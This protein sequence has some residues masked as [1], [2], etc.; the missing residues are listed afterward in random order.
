MKYEILINSVYRL[1]LKKA[2]KVLNYYQSKI[3]FNNSEEQQSILDMITQKRNID[4]NIKNGLFNTLIKR[5]NE[6]DVDVLLDYEKYPNI[7]WT[8]IIE[9]VDK[10]ILKELFEENIDKLSSFLIETYILNLPKKDQAKITDQYLDKLDQTSES[11]YSFYYSLK[12]KTRNKIK[13]KISNK[14]TD[15]LLLKIKDLDESQLVEI[16]KNN[17]KKI[18]KQDSNALVELILKKGT[19]IETYNLF[20]ELYRSK[21]IKCSNSNFKLLFKKY[22][23]LVNDYI[24]TNNQSKIEY[25]KNEKIIEDTILFDLF[26][27]KFYKIGV[28][29]T[30]KLF[31]KVI[32]YGCDDFTVHVVLELISIAFLN[33][34]LLK[35]LN[36]NTIIKIIDEYVE[37]CNQQIYT[38][39][40]LV[41]IL[42]KIK[43]SKKQNLI[44]KDHIKAV[45]ACGQV[46]RSGVITD[47]SDIFIDI[48]NE[49]SKDLIRRCIKDNTLEENIQLNSI[50]YRLT[51]GTLPFSKV[52]T[53][54]TYKGLIYLTKCGQNIDEVDY[55]TLFFNDY[56]INKLNVSPIL[57]ITKQAFNNSKRDISQP[58]FDRMGMQIYCLF[59]KNKCEYLLNQNLNYDKL[60]LYFDG[61]D[62]TK[63]EIEENGE[64][65]LNEE[66]V[67]F[68][69]GKGNM[70]EHCS[71]INKMIREELP[72]FE[73]Y[74]REFCNNFEKLEKECNGVISVKRVIKYFENIELPIELKPDEVYLKHYLKEMNTTNEELLQKA[75][76][77]CK[78]SRRRKYSSIPKVKEKLD[79]FS[80]E[81]LD[82]KDPLALIVGY[83]SHCCF[84]VDGM[85]YP[86]LK[87]AMTSQNGRI[88]VVYYNNQFIAQSWIWRNGCT[89]CFD[90]VEVAPAYYNLSTEDKDKVVD[91]YIKTAEKMIEISKENESELE[92]IKVVTVGRANSSFNRLEIL[93]GTSPKPIEPNLNAYDS[94][95]QKILSGNLPNNPKFGQVLIQYKDE[96]KI[97]KIE[98]LDNIDIDKKDEII[99]TINSIDYQVNNETKELNFEE[100]K[101]IIYT[102]EWYI[103]SK[104]DGKL[105]GNYIKFDKEI[106]CEYN[107]FYSEEESTM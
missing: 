6:K 33:D 83:L 73:I 89:A 45:I 20:F 57:K 72:E 4:K 98:D 35:S 5:L 46:L 90:S 48:R 78:E 3:R 17:S 74:F 68:L 42:N 85:S 79:E 8:E 100:Y 93:N 50:F 37:K 12:K 43:N 80:F 65:K 62:Y 107:K 10:D 87:H 105:E 82:L 66:L 14:I 44:S 19:K 91:V 30:L 13:Y 52:Y 104:K 53:I 64:P 2:I 41:D 75:I 7:L 9:Y 18:I 21:I 27:E 32:Y 58:E 97:K 92:R 22:K 28:T 94:D 86:T 24:Y 77:L 95:S 102:D 26:K 34:K 40:D 96:R 51:K 103:I 16:L 61:I 63:I 56:Q 55:V 15:D 76:D 54:Y 59:G 23:C 49:F 36:K 106:E 11:F 99:N 60:Q 31:D 70:K 67:N 1:P 25:T 69:F 81:L 29:N 88:F 39:Q 101:K 84:L 47:Q 71:I 38:L